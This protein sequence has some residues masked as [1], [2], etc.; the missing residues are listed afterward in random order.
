MDLEKGGP[1][2]SHKGGLC[3]INR[4]RSAIVDI[5]GT[6]P[7]SWHAALKKKQTKKKKERLKKTKTKKN[8]D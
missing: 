2:Q 7:F 8:K 3:H 5:F 1:K 4:I 6:K